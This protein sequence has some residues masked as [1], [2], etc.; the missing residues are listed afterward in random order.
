MPTVDAK[1]R[2]VLP[3]DVRERLGL[4]AGSEV[5][6]REDD[7][8]VVVE[9]EDDPA[10]IL[11]DQEALIERAAAGRDAPDEELD[12][13]ARDHVETIQRQTGET[14]SCDE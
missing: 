7:G 1:G 14:S 6:V 3:K 8:R 11:S 13:L 12:A 9:P 4:T 2:I 5:E 10:E